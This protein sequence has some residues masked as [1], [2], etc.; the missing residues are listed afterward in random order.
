MKRE[1][2]CL[3]EEAAAV[4][5]PSA[6]A[7]EVVAAAV[8][9]EAQEVAAVAVAA[10]AEEEVP[11]AVA[12]AKVVILSVAEIEV[13]PLSEQVLLLIL[14]DIGDALM[15]VLVEVQVADAEQVVALY[16]LF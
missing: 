1:E 13:D 3:W 2:G 5:V 7:A 14:V 6:V 8:P 12:V 10:V 9:L 15:A 4:A 11:S 16:L